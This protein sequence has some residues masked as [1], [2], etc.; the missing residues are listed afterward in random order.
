MGQQRPLRPG[1]GILRKWQLIFYG[2]DQN[3][4]RIPRNV[5]F[6]PPAPSQPAEG[7]FSANGFFKP[8]PSFGGFFPF[9]DRKR[10]SVNETFTF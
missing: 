6:R 3:P 10:R 1:Q 8:P 5:E 4:V 7:G 9:T 2:T